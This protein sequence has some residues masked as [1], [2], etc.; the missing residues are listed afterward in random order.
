MWVAAITK[1]Q[2]IQTIDV[3]VTA[4]ALHAF[5]RDLYGFLGR[6]EDSTSAVLAV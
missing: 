3:S 4:E 2:I 6:V 5:Q 1:S